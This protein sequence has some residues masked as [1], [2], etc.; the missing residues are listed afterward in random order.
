MAD[1]H[2]GI[3]KQNLR[4][5][6]TTVKS[7]A[8]NFTDITGNHVFQAIPSRRKRTQFYIGIP[9]QFYSGILGMIWFDSF[10]KNPP[11][12]KEMLV[13]RMHLDLGQ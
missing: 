10:E 7:T 6:G 9:G 5:R 11:L 4:Q 2:Y 8:A 12:V 3:G 13:F 1:S